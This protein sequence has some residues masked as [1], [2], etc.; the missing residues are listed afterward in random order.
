M[1]KENF[2]KV[3]DAIRINGYAHFNMQSFYAEIENEFDYENVLKKEYPAHTVENVWNGLRAD[4]LAGTKMFSCNTIGCIAG[5]ATAVANDWK[6]L[7]ILDF[8]CG[9]NDYFI[10]ASNRYLGLTKTEGKN[11][12]FS[13]ENSVWKLIGYHE[14]NANRELKFIESDNDDYEV[15]P[16]DYDYWNHQDYMVALTSIS[17]DMAISVLTRIMNGG[18]ILD[19][20][21]GIPV[22][23]DYVNPIESLKPK[24]KH[25]QV[26]KEEIMQS[27]GCSEAYAEVIATYAHYN[28][29]MDRDSDSEN[30]V[31]HWKSVDLDFRNKKYHD[32]KEYA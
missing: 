19:N 3:I 13:S 21:F 10:N 5:F 12:Y 2:Q 26:A 23:L 4:D 15:D 11:L 27:L 8:N 31:K 16:H 14:W 9:S 7:D 20:G 30:V 18:I 29:L 1:N 17:P 25:S 24:F 6:F 22:I 32:W 28:L